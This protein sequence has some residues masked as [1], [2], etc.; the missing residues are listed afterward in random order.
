MCDA[1]Q[2]ILVKTEVKSI[3]AI[4]AACGRLGLSMPKHGRARMFSWEGEPLQ[5]VEGLLL[6]LPGWRYPVCINPENGQMQYDNHKEVWGEQKRLDDF[7]QAY[8]VE[9]ARITAFEQGM[10]CY[11]QVLADGSIEVHACLGE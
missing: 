9:Q 8:A 1:C 10:T 2:L 6:Y 5:F 7:M 11:E 4:Q 3:Q